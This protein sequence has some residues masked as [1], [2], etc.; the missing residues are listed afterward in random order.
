[1]TLQSD[2]SALSSA[3]VDLQRQLDLLLGDLSD[4]HS[5]A[6]ALNPNLAKVC[7]HVESLITEA[8]AVLL[9]PELLEPIT[10]ERVLH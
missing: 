2:A 10:Q 9:V 8:E 1:M 7:L 6:L 5:A 4:L 3:L